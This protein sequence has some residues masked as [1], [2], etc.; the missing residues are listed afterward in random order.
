MPCQQQII[1]PVLGGCMETPSRRLRLGHPAQMLATT[2]DAGTGN[3]DSLLATSYPTGQHVAPELGDNTVQ[4]RPRRRA[5]CRHADRPG[6]RCRVPAPN[7]ASSIPNFNRH[8]TTSSISGSRG[9]RAPADECASP[10]GWNSCLRLAQCLELHR[11]GPG[12]QV[13]RSPGGN[14][15]ISRMAWSASSVSG[16]PPTGSL[17]R[18]RRRTVPACRRLRI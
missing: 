8:R 3:P 18:N 14:G 16:P 2:R 13:D 9:N 7:P 5:S 17:P 4:G 11:D 15:E 12:H 10:A 1:C 6:G